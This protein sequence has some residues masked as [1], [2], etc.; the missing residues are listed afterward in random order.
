MDTERLAVAG[1]VATVLLVSLLSGPLVAGIDLSPPPDELQSAQTGNATVDVVS[2]PENA[3]L[4]RGAFGAE[5]P[6]TLTVP[7][8]TVI[9]SNVTGRPLLVYKVRIPELGYQRG[10]THFLD[11]SAEGRRSLNL[12]SATLEEE[13]SQDSYR[14]EL[15]VILRGDGPERTIYRGNVTVEVVE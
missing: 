4:E 1:V 6:Y 13:L 8:A 14:G 3:R 7:D 2:A 9:I 11:A 5:A 12:E 15:F 10:T